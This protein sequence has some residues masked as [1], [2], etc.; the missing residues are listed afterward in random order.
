MRA[1]DTDNCPVGI[2]TQKDHLR[3]RLEIAKSAVQLKNFLEG[4]V[5]LM[6]VLARACGHDALSEFQPNDLSTFD[7]SV[8]ELTG[9]R[10]AGPDQTP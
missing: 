3:R 1:C 2:A 4:S 5:H 7:R 10:F 9:I 6:Q 8:S